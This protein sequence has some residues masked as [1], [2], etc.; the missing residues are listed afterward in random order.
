MSSNNIPPSSLLIISYVENKICEIIRWKYFFTIISIVDAVF[1]ILITAD[2]TYFTF[3][4][5]DSAWWWK[6]SNILSECTLFV[7]L[8]VGINLAFTRDN[9][10]KLFIFRYRYGDLF[11]FMINAFATFPL[12]QCQSVQLSAPLFILQLTV[13]FVFFFSRSFVALLAIA[14]EY[15]FNK[16]LPSQPL[17]V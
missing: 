14:R 7:Y 4:C 1:L 2:Y 5:M 11:F 12:M 13:A 16:V 9:P 3:Q 6:V 10:P 15:A 8:S 17:Q